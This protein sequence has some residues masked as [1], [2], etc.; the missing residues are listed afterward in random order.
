[1]SPLSLLTHARNND[2]TD[3]KGTLSVGCAVK[4]NYLVYSILKSALNIWSRVDLEVPPIAAAP[5]VRIPEN[6]N[7]FKDGYWNKEYSLV[8]SMIFMDLRVSTNF[9]IISYG[10]LRFDFRLINSAKKNVL[11]ILGRGWIS[12]FS[13]FQWLEIWKIQDFSRMA[14]GKMSINL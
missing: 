6:L 14:D 11:F 12:G 3:A 1:M 5:M 4:A 13:P 2:H 7:F 9:D 8:N 10:K